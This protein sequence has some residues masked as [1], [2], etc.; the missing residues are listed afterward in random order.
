MKRFHGFVFGLVLCCGAA[1]AAEKMPSATSFLFW[2]PAEQA[3]GYKNV[4]KIFP[5]RVIKRGGAVRELPVTGKPFDVSYAFHGKTWNT[6][7]FMKA[8]NTSGLLVVKDGKIILERYGLGRKESD[9]WTSFSVAKSITSTLVGAAIKDGTIKSL[10]SNIT[11][12]LPGLKKTAYDG[13]TVRDL[14]TMRSGVAWNED[15]T[16][17]KSDVNIFAFQPKPK[18]GGNP[19]VAFMA[20]HPRAHKP[21]TTFH[22]D[23]GETDLAGILV[24]RATHM[25]LSDYLSKAVWSKIGAEQDAVWMLDQAGVELGG[26]CISMTLRDYARF[27]LFFMDGGKG[28][29]PDGWVKQASSKQVMSDFQGLGYGYFWWTHDDGTYEAVGIF[30]QSIFIDPKAHLV[31][32]TNSAWPEAD[33]TPRYIVHDAYV[34]AVRKALR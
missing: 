26:C 13:V 30:G 16:D 25:P 24:A 27:G 19:V 8:A 23:T 11:D 12:Y 3:L 18:D 20:K 34:A 17:P 33:A 1:A 2:T 31:I 22:Y 7:A 6:D 14:I 5:T 32:V 10:N 9:R 28:V 4:E 21:G 15:Y 29:L